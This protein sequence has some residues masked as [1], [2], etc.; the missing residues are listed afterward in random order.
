MMELVLREE[1][2]V[3]ADTKVEILIWKCA[4]QKHESS[5]V[6]ATIQSWYSPVRLVPGMINEYAIFFYLHMFLCVWGAYSYLI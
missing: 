4:E 6:L 1:L 2:L 5:H 3:N